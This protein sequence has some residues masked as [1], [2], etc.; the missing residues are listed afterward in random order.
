MN[1]RDSLP[2]ETRRR[3][4]L[5]FCELSFQ[6]RPELV[7]IVR[8]FVSEFYDGTLAD[9]D[10]SFRV[11]LATHELLENALKYSPD[12][13]ATVRIEVDARGSSAHIRICTR[14]RA[15]PEDTAFIRR[16]VSEM[17][18]SPDANLYYLD[19]IRRN[20]RRSE[21]SGLGLARIYAEAEMQV[22]VRSSRGVV[23]VTA[24]TDV[25]LSEAAVSARGVA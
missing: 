25:E 5:G 12:G 6:R 17:R 22:S 18:G 7:S 16:T 11:A 10:A 1:D 13:Q 19:V 4:E 2:P 14:N 20:A 24:E 15:A 8:R 21:G 23:T 9:P 3:G